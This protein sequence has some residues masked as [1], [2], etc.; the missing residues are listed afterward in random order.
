MLV[1][2][3]VRVHI[4]VAIVLHLIRQA[5]AF[6]R[7]GGVTGITLRG[8]LLQVLARD[9]HNEQAPEALDVGQEGQL[10][11]IGR[12]SG[13]DVFRHVARHLELVACVQVEQEDIRASVRL[14]SNTIQFGSGDQ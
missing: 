2:R 3:I 11:A 10:L 1:R 4:H 9:I 14:L 7:P 13:E 6:R 5:V 8:N 12:P